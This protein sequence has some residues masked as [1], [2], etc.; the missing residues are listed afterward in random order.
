MQT[1]KYYQPNIKQII[2][3]QS[4]IY[5]YLQGQVIAIAF[6]DKNLRKI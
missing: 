4:H 3:K 6:C 5:M 2:Q 1:N